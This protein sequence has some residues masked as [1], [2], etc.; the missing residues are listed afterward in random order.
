MKQLQFVLPAG[1][2]LP[3]PHLVGAG[4][5][6]GRT[7]PESVRLSVQIEL[8][9]EGKAMMCRQ[10]VGAIQRPITAT[11]SHVE[12]GLEL[13][14]DSLEGI[15]FLII[16]FLSITAQYV[17][18]SL[19]QGSIHP[20][21]ASKHGE[22]GGSICGELLRLGALQSVNTV[23]KV[24]S[25]HKVNPVQSREP[26]Q[27]TRAGETKDIEPEHSFG[28]GQSVP[29]LALFTPK[30]EGCPE[31]TGNTKK[32]SFPHTPDAAA[33]TPVRLKVCAGARGG[34][35]YPP[36]GRDFFFFLIPGT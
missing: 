32:S 33:R 3:S 25:K 2:E 28:M 15:H 31:E 4:R 23:D 19:S 18:A 24:V 22:Q 8:S 1:E 26:S 14:P 27:I 29:R 16:T 35:H 6:Q 12:E 11:R 30:Q 7:R 9:L 13:R 36:A 10:L 34:G 5:E 20:F 17:P 21:Q